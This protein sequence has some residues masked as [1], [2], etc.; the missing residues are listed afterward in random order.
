MFLCVKH[1]TITVPKSPL[2]ALRLVG[3]E[4]GAAFVAL[5][6]LDSYLDYVRDSFVTDTLKA[7]DAIVKP[8]LEMDL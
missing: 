1:L 2:R 4:I 6:N 8:K 5:L 7:H 3:Q